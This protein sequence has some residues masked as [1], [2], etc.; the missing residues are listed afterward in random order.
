MAQGVVCVSLSLGV[1]I[2]TNAVE[3]EARPSRDREFAS[4][5]IVLSNVMLWMLFVAVVIRNAMHV[6]LDDVCMYM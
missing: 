1:L 4:A 5:F 2:S 6:R 3:F